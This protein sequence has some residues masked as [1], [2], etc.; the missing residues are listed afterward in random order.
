MGITRARKRLYLSLARQR[1]IFN[2]VNYN[3][4]SRFVEEIPKRLVDDVM[5]QSR[6]HFAA[7]EPIRRPHNRD[8]GR[9]LDFGAP[10]MGQLNIPGVTKGFVPST[11]AKVSGSAMMNMYQPGDRVMHRKFGEGTVVDV[12]RAGTDARITID[13]IAYGQKAFS[14]AIAPI[15]KIED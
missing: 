11:A 15:F 3:R 1:T 14:L 10:G 5:A 8:T 4:M 12:Q 13:F 2:Q 9:K 6:Q 7:E